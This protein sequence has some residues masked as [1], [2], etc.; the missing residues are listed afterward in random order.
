MDQYLFRREGPAFRRM[1]LFC[2]RQVRFLF[3]KKILVSADRKQG[4]FHGTSIR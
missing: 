1:P 4:N 2:F 3:V